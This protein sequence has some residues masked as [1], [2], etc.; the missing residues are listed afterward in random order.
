MTKEEAREAAYNWIEKSFIDNLVSGNED[1]SKYNLVY[2]MGFMRD[3]VDLD[4]YGGDK[5]FDIA[6]ELNMSCEDIQISFDKKS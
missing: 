3:S 5:Y 6:E 2:E 4:Y 1:N